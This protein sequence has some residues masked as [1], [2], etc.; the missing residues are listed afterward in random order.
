M[1]EA[2]SMSR[3]VVREIEMRIV[4]ESEIEL[5]PCPTC[6]S[7]DVID[8]WREHGC[9]ECYTWVRGI[10]EYDP[11]WLIEIGRNS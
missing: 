5:S 11:R 1:A 4:K 8:G 9:V 2:I 10:L 6:G 3:F 7:V